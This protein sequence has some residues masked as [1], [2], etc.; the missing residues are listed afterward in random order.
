[1]GRISLGF[2]TSLRSVMVSVPKAVDTSIAAPLCPLDQQRSKVLYVNGS[3][4]RQPPPTKTPK[5]GDW[6]GVDPMLFINIPVPPNNTAGQRI[7]A[8]YSGSALVCLLLWEPSC[9]ECPLVNT[10]IYQQVRDFPP[11]Q[12]PTVRWQPISA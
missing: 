12:T 10:F 3:T 7:R 4:A 2:S 11:C 1:M 6:Q 8:L 9:H 5:T